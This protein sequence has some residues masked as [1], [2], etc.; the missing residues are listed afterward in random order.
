MES[1]GCATLHPPVPGTTPPRTD[2]STVLITA[3][4][5]AVSRN[6]WYVRV[7][8]ETCRYFPDWADR[9]VTAGRYLEAER[10]SY[11]AGG[12]AEEFG[13]RAQREW[14]AARA[15]A[16]DLEGSGR[17]HVYVDGL[18]PGYPECP[19]PSDRDSGLAGDDG[20]TRPASGPRERP[21]LALYSSQ[22]P[23]DH[24]ETISVGGGV[25]DRLARKPVPAASL[26][27]KWH[28]LRVR[29]RQFGVFS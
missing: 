6:S 24:F 20:I 8:G 7:R 5:D 27:A 2:G 12:Y 17:W 25:R 14:R 23:T 11:A 9:P 21:A 4:A 19:R 29:H 10:N 22:Q 1:G 13:Y 16:A 28:E 26:L 3:V 18:H 15:S